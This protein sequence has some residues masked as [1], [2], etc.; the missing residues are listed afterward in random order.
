MFSQLLANT[1]VFLTALPFP[2][3]LAFGTVLVIGASAL[4]NLLL[5]LLGVRVAETVDSASRN[6]PRMP[7]RGQCPLT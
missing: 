7:A 5:L 4:V 1:V 3:A 2:V 6:R